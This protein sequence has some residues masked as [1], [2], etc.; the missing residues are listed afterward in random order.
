MSLLLGAHPQ[1]PRP[2]ESGLVRRRRRRLLALVVLTALLLA[3]VL[4]SAVL[5]QYAVPA[6]D[7]L[8]VIGARIGLGQGPS[9]PVVASVLWDIRF[10]RIALGVLV[11][12]ALAAG[13]V[14][15]QALFANPLAEPGVI[16]VSS[17]A[18]VGASAAIVLAPHALAGLAVPAAAFAS[19]CAAAFLVHALA[20]SQGRTR[21][22]TLVLTGVAVTAVCSALTSI[23]TYV[24]PTTARDQIVFWQMGSLNGATWSQVASVALIVACCLAGASAIAPGLDTLALGE[25]AAAH[26]GVDVQRLRT[27][28]LVLTALLTA[29][30]V[31]WAGV[32]SFVGLIVPHLLRLLIGPVNRWL[33]PASVIGGAVLLT[34]SD[35]A[36]RTLVPYADLPIGI[37][38]ALAGGPTFFLLLR[39]GMRTGGIA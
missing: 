10:P 26:V 37:F 18:A 12:A 3:G 8:S 31:S 11:G 13:G 15:M 24:A 9:D 19:G 38:T 36:A 1:P 4:C 17:G 21:V 25:R 27:L 22:T 34:W 23:T 7:V 20:R 2:V 14:V 33:L 39:R 32:I 5:G 29:A 35:I 6:R 30:A 16:G 28:S